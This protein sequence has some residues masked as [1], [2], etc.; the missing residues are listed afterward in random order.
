M[1]GAATPRR[2]ST[3]CG[4]RRPKLILGDLVRVGQDEAGVAK[5]K[6]TDR[7]EVIA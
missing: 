1:I 2:G 5:I 7:D 3:L 6:L 4:F